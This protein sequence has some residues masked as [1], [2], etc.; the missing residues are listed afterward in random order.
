M[1]DGVWE[2]FLDTIA[3]VVLAVFTIMVVHMGRD[4]EGD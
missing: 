1:F 3:G 4:E 2:W